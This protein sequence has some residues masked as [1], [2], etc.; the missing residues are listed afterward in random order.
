MDV[1]DGRRA[2]ENLALLHDTASSVIIEDVLQN[3]D[4][5]VLDGAGILEAMQEVNKGIVRSGGSIADLDD[6][7]SSLSEIGD[8][9]V[10]ED[11]DPDNATAIEVDDND[12]EAETE[13][14]EDSPQKLRVHKNVLLT[15]D[16]KAGDLQLDMIGTAIDDSENLTTG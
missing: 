7:S 9:A 4:R 6:R 1:L 3:S 11:P 2:E 5:A 10:V 15:A 16:D 13:R 12:T 14:L 8:G